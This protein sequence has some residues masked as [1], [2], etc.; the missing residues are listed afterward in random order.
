MFN[1]TNQFIFA[2]VKLGY[3]T[4]EN[5]K[6]NERHKNFYNAR[7]R[8]AG[9]VIYEPLY[10]HKG[11]R[12]LHGQLGIDNDD[13]IEGLK[14]LN[15]IVKKNG[16]LA[17]AHINHPGRLTN[18]EIPDKIVISSTDRPCSDG[19]VPKQM[20][21]EDMEEVLDLLSEAAIRC[22][23]AGFDV[24]ELQLGHG[25][26]AAQFLSAE[27]NTRTDEYGGEFENRI[28]FPLEMFEAVRKSTS[29][30]IIV[31]VT[32]SC[33]T[34]KGICIEEAVNFIEE[35]KKRD[36][37]VFHIVVGSGCNTAP[38]FY[39]HMFTPKGKTW[40]IAKEIKDRT[41]VK[42]IT[43][44]RITTLM[45]I[46]HLIERFKSDYI[47]IGRALIADPDFI[48]K[49]TGEVD[50]NIKPCMSC[51]D[52][53]LGGVR[54]GR[55]LGCMVNPMIG[56][57]LTQVKPT[58]TPKKIAVVG[59]GLSGMEFALQ[60]KL[61]GHKVTIF[62]K[63]RLGGQFNLAWLPPKKGAFKELVDYYKIEIADKNV[64]VIYKEADKYDL[65]GGDFDEIVL[66][67]GAI[68]KTPPIKG[69]NKFLWSDFL[70]DNS[71]PKNK[72]VLI[73]GG[74]LIGIEVASKL[75]DHDNNVI[76]I[77]MGSEIAKGMEKMQKEITINKLESKGTRIFV[78]HTVTEV[79][80]ANSTVIIEGK[81][82]L[83]LN[84]INHIVVTAG[85]KS[86]TVLEEEI[87][88][89]KP[90]HKIGDAVK[91]AKAQDAI[92]HGFRLGVEI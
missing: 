74:G 68:P 73:I 83:Q 25:Y 85:M 49:Y 48:G 30:P 2:P 27:V 24:I 23:K 56:N 38:W 47:A 57:E 71:M 89:R 92:L 78:D 91:P 44:G 60:A 45:D 87:K 28:K 80:N 64:R 76:I 18:P 79:K 32:G 65:L 15:N 17:V 42:I 88:G 66:A 59:G 53:C 69:L 35:L 11:L 77:E 72:R 1:P 55:G 39:Q 50:G 51:S 12:E 9:T 33:M 14:E 62:E 5:G 29:L 22:E 10:I 4:D 13:K 31:R 61:R 81:R 34:E 20:D 75:V 67:T 19:A 6:V 36:V 84:N 46:E 40:E 26:L 86:N 90:Y 37:E 82:T 3:C 52:G 41:G 16:A 54:D 43:V 21:K 58:D 7:S 8:H 70:D 63:E